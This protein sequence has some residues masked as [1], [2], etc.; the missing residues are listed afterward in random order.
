MKIGGNARRRT[1]HKK[2]SNKKGR[3]VLPTA[4]RCSSRRR[5]AVRRGQPPR[6]MRQSYDGETQERFEDLLL[7]SPLALALRK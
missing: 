1:T 5:G 3:G 4:R 7:L 6:D 2:G